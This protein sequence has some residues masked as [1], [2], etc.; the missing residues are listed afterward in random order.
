MSRKALYSLD[1]TN[2]LY[3]NNEDLDIS[4]NHKD[5]NL[6]I[7]NEK[8][9]DYVIQVH[10]NSEVNETQLVRF[11]WSDPKSVFLVA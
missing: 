4:L 6:E 1:N 8:N 11:N 10:K 7:K 2:Q 3:E 9:E 5:N